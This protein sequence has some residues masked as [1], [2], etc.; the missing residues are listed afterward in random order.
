MN[1]YVVKRL[2][3]KDWYLNRGM[4]LAAL[5]AGLGTMEAVAAAKATN[6]AV[7]LGVIVLATILIGMGAVIMSTSVM[8]RKQQTLPFVMSLPI[9]YLEYTTSKI[10]GSLLI[11]GVLWLALLAGIITT[12]L[13]TPWF[14]HGLIPF[15][16]IMAVEVLVSTCLIAA[17]S[18]TTESQGWMIGVTQVGSIGLNAVGF[19]IVRLPGIG[20]TM[21]GHTI[22]WSS[23]SIL[24]L[25]VEFAVIALIIGTTFF[26]QSRK[27]DFI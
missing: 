3:Y 21:S 18:V 6:L 15:V 8:E 19:S 13:I 20:G 12:I 27:R 4:F 14:P 9:S 17:V 24:I 22:Q 16:V 5:I 2:I 25:L 1:T 7:I 10:V 11:F 23:T 26:V